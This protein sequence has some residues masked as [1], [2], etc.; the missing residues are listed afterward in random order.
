MDWDNF[1][2]PK[3]PFADLFEEVKASYLHT[4]YTKLLSGDWHSCAGGIYNCLEAEITPHESYFEN[5]LNS[6]SRGSSV[7]EGK[8]LCTYGPWVREYL[9]QN[10]PEIHPSELHWWV[11]QDPGGFFRFFL[12]QLQDDSDRFDRRVDYADGCGDPPVTFRPWTEP[13]LAAEFRIAF[14][15]DPAAEPLNFD[16]FQQDARNVVTN[17]DPSFSQ[18]ADDGTQHAIEYNGKV[19][20]TV[21]E[22]QPNDDDIGVGSWAFAVTQRIPD[23]RVISRLGAG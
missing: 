14:E 1:F 20:L 15:L 4:G 9:H 12:M 18:D 3:G 5:L 22:H 16:I 7:L 2:I 23:C 13:P 21:T 11:E 19:V 6:K 10:R 8:Q 17:Q